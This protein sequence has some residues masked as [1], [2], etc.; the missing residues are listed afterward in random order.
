MKKVIGM[1]MAAV[2][3][4][5]L[6]GVAFARWNGPGMGRGPGCYQNADTETLKNFRQETLT[7]REE[8]ATKKLDLRAEYDKPEPDTARISSLKKDVSDLRS[9][10]QAIAEKNGLPAWGPGPGGGMMAGSRGPG[11]GMMMRA[12][13]PCSF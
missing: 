1:I 10:I 11:R 5:T 13:C 7:L 6:A 2:M 9:K 3:V 8:L 4:L 12:D